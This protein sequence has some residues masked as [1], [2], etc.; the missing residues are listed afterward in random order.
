MAPNDAV[1]ELRAGLLKMPEGS[2]WEFYLPPELGFSN[3]LGGA[4]TP[5]NT[6]LI[7][8]FEFMGKTNQRSV[9]KGPSPEDI[10]Y[11]SRKEM[12]PGVVLMPSGL[13]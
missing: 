5:P 3:R 11:L 13:M 1:K 8:T 4:E 2:I 7:C 10:Q 12:E 6:V 9:V